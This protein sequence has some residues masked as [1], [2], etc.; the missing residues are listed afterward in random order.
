MYNLEPLQMSLQQQSM[1]HA[2]M[3]NCVLTCCCDALCHAAPCRFVEQEVERVKVLFDQKEGRLRSERDA[4][5][6]QLKHLQAQQE[7]LEAQVCGGAVGPPL[8][9]VVRC[10]Y[11]SF[12]IRGP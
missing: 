11:A 1:G 4:A 8:T 2:D 7:D 10:G 3:C 5:Q 12:P 9:A 6:R